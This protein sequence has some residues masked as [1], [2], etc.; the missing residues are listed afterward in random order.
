[1][2]AVL[3]IQRITKNYG[4]IQALKGVSFHVPKGSVFGILSPNGSE[5]QCCSGF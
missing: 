3:S 1:M 4:S 2:A 5:K